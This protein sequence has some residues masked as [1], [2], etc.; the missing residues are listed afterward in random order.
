MGWGGGGG[1]SGLGWVSGVVAVVVGEAEVGGGV[2]GDVAVEVVDGGGVGVGA[3]GAAGVAADVA[4]VLVPP[5][6]P[7][8]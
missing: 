2:V 3:S 7:G 1:L 4:A 5:D 6:E 8:E